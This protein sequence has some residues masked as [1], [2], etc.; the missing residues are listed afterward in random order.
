MTKKTFLFLVIFSVLFIQ[1][2]IAT[3]STKNV[4][5]KSFSKPK[6]ITTPRK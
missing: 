1:I 5:D 6:K 4:K 2:D 3:K